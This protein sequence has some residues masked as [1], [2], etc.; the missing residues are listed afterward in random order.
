MAAC[1]GCGLVI[2]SRPVSGNSYRLIV[3]AWPG[4]TTACPVICEQKLLYSGGPDNDPG[5]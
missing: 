5:Q 2:V 3:A 4:I 1:F